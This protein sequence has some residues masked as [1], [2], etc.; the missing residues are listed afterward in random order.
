M[1][2]Y[3]HLN[4]LFDLLF[5]P[6]LLLY[7]QGLCKTFSFSNDNLCTWVDMKFGSPFTIPFRLN[8]IL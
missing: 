6:Y 3:S 7:V 5:I 8:Y 2:V 4:L 1:M